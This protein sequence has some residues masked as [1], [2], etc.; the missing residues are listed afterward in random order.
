MKL[1][2]YKKAFKDGTGAFSKSLMT[3]NFAVTF[4]IENKAK[5]F[6]STEPPSPQRH[7]VKVWPCIEMCGF[8]V[9]R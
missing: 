3:P 7:E 6:D 2:Q 4:F 1:K 9:N 8:L 5:A